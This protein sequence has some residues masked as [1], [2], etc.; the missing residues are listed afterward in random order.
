MAVAGRKAWHR[1]R[2]IGWLPFLFF[3][4]SA[5]PAF[6]WIA[7]VAPQQRLGNCLLHGLRRAKFK[8]LHSDCLISRCL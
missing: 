2:L 1:T 3:V 4:L 7:V 5:P 6:C 8:V